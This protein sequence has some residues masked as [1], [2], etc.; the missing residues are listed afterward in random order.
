MDLVLSLLA[1]SAE[2][3]RGFSQMKG[4]KSQ[5]HAKVKAD[6]MTDLLIIQLNS[7]DT[8]NFDPRKAIH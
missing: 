1:S 6:S 7:P 2:A 4:T 5:M 3:E 8:Y